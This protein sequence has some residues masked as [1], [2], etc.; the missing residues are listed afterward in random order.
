MP[1]WQEILA[2]DGRAVWQAAYRVLGNK[3]DAD[4]C[5]QEAFLA[6]LEFSR[7]EEV[8]HWRTFLQRVATARA[9]DRLRRRLRQSARRQAADW[10]TVPDLA[11]TP[12]QTAEEAELAGR[13]RAALAR[14]P[15]KQAEVFCLH[16]LQGWSYQ[17]IAQHL[18]VS[19]DA[20]RVLLHRARKRLQVLL[21]ASSPADVSRTE[22]RGPASGRGPSP[23]PE[24]QSS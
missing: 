5:F 15:R 19:T 16:G 23:T 9:V 11:P 12:H 17:E 14:I 18:A 6:A 10:D 24:E 13:L 4:D 22:G 8:R 3:A 2:R 1:D 7:R 20:V 21:S